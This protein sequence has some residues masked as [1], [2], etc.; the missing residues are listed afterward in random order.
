MAA[1][2]VGGFFFV[3]CF[4]CCALSWVE[5]LFALQETG[6]TLLYADWSTFMGVS[7]RENRREVEEVMADVGG[8]VAYATI[9]CLGRRIAFLK[10][11]VRRIQDSSD[12]K[13][14]IT[15]CAVDVIY[16]V[17]AEILS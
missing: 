4:A 8:S 9:M 17:P 11:L 14:S 12:G 3:V 10:K 1:T 7:F 13:T 6:C 16:R 2:K 15:P 5:G